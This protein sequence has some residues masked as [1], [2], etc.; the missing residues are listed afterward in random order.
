MV[1]RKLMLDLS[2]DIGFDFSQLNVF[3]RI[4]MF[5]HTPT[6][7]EDSPCTYGKIAIKQAATEKGKLYTVEPE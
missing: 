3:Q 4:N 1:M 5:D 7:N 2:V 6:G